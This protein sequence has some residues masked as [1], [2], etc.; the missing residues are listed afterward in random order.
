MKAADALRLVDFYSKELEIEDH[1][2]DKR[3]LA[4][5]RVCV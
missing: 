5:L 1:L 2:R 4:R 3:N